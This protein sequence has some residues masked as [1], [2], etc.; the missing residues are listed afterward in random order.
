MRIFLVGP[1]ASGKTTLARSLAAAL[2]GDWLD[3]DTLTQ[4]HAGMS[5]AELVA[6][7]GWEAFRDL[8]SAALAE[9]CAMPAAAAPL[10]VATGGGMVLRP[11]NRQAMR[12]AGLV[13]WLDAPGELITARL[14]AHLDP[15]QRPS[16]TGDD[17]VAEA[18]RVA[19]SRESLYRE[20]AH[21]VLDAAQ[22]LTELVEQARRRINDHFSGSTQQ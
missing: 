19:A 1:R 11:E 8:E 4:Q 21:A 10:L 13:L 7:R 15:G 17:P 2:D 5:I 9:A 6:A 3:T 16:L 18:A 14:A 12:E 22:P 20:A